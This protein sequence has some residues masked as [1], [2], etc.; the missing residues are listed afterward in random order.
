[1]YVPNHFRADDLSTIKGFITDNEFALVVS[2]QGGIPIAS[3]LLVE[4]Q[5]DSQNNLF[6]NGHMAR[7]NPQWKSFDPG[8]EVLTVFQGP[9]TYVSPMWYTIQAVP[10]W[11]YLAV[12]AYGHARI[13]D[14]RSELYQLLERLVDRHEA[15]SGT[16]NRFLLKDS[17]PDFIENMMNAVVGFQIS[18]TKIEASFKL[19]QNRSADDYQR[20]II[21]LKKR[22]DESSHA[23][24][25]AME[26]HRH[27]GMAQEE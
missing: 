17:P 15:A 23:V 10:T 19:S 21:E 20:I 5:E 7:N 16:V 24:A 2:T 4:L 3:H 8:S 13:I 25:D 14:D 27:E 18:V 12:H 11:N 22:A 6:L 26:R 1:M 9:H